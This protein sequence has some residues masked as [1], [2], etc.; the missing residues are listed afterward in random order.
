[1]TALGGRRYAAVL[2]SPRRRALVTAELAGLAVTRVEPELAEWDYG[3]YEGR[4]T[5][6][7]RRGRP[8]WDVWTDGCPGR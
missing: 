6:E 8:G 4:T 2:S 5:A 7:I 3:R 1:M